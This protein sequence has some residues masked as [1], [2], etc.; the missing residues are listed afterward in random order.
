VAPNEIEA[1]GRPAS[2]A[3]PPLAKP[4]GARYSPRPDRRP[5]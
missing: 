4:L 5:A 2:W 3:P 1:G